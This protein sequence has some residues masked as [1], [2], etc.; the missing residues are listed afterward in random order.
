MTEE[1]FIQEAGA[2]ADSF[3]LMAL[4]ALKKKPNV[5]DAVQTV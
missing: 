1:R 4:H 2:Y 3:Y 5:E